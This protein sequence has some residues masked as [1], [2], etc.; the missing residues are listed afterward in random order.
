VLCDACGVVPDQFPP[1]VP[2]YERIGAVT[3]VAAEATGLRP[4]TPVFAGTVDGVAAALEAG[5]TESGCVAEMTGTST[6]LIIPNLTGTLEPAFIAVPHALPGRHL[7]FGALVSSGASLN[8]YRDQFGLAE[9][10]A[11]ALLHTD[12]F[13]LLTQQASRAPSGSG[14]VLFLPYMMGERS[15]IWHT[16]ARGV[17]FGLSLTT[18]RAAIIRS[19][20]EGTAYALRHNIDV[21]RAA[22]VPVNEVR[23][24]GGGTR[25]GLWNQIKAD[26][27]GLPV[28]LPEA[29][30]GAP[31]GDAVLVGMGL[32]LY[33]DVPAAL[34][35]MVKIVTS[36]LP[37]PKAH[38]QYL[39]LYAIYRRLYE[40]LRSDFDALA[41]TVDRF[42]G[43]DNLG[44]NSDPSATD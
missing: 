36:Y 2:A 11:G 1:V 27:L 22:G 30:V 38:A 32:G 40:H 19:I 41:G 28:N 17:W 16:N 3:A 43:L 9:Q 29:P 39:E 26:V 8:W 10:Q 12:V 34:H 4:G 14:G 7:L 23:S 35:Q 13:D 15:P 6:V 37:D 21:A 24:V 33:P 20:L 18:S 25:S 5:V 31:F 42:P 44:R